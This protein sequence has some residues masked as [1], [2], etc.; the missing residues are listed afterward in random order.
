MIL[1]G[2]GQ[3]I[4]VPS[5]YQTSREHQQLHAKRLQGFVA[6][7]PGQTNPLEVVHDVESEKEQLEECHIGNP[8]LGG[9]LG[10][11]VIVSQFADMLFDP[12]S[13]GIEQVHSP[14]AHFQVG[15]KNM[16]SVLD[17]LEQGQLPCFC[18]VLWDRS[19]YNHIAVSLFPSVGSVPKLAYLPAVLESCESATPGF[20]SDRVALLGF[21]HNHISVSFSV[22][23]FDHPLPIEPRVHAETD[24]RPGNTFGHLGQADFDEGHG[25]GGAP[26]IA[27]TQRTMPELLGTGLESQKR[28]VR[29]PAMFLGVVS[30]P[31]SFYRPAVDHQNCGIQIEDQAGPLVGPVEKSPPQKIVDS[32]DL[33]D[34]LG[35]EPFEESS[36]RGLVREPAKSHN[37]LEG[38]VVLEDLSLVDPLHSSDDGIENGHDHVGGLKI[39]E[40]RGWSETPLQQTFETQL[41]TKTLNQEQSSK[42]SEV[43]FLEGNGQTSQSSWHWTQCY[44]LGSVVSMNNFLG[45]NSGSSSKITP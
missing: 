42:V 29:A 30:H 3:T 35:S 18:G 43:R 16:V 37:F 9:D 6:I 26:G 24:T 11:R 2:Q 34:L 20:E 1:P 33:S 45:F 8:V 23:E 40:T 28:M 4:S 17:V 21:G 38:P 12:G 31:S 15:D 41:L 32:Y 14:S 22:E 13:G 36:D 10:Q 5:F 44:L 7:A 39:S 27:G 19:A 25:P